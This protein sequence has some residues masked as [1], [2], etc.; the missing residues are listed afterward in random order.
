M[1]CRYSIFE[2][3]NLF[4]LKKACKNEKTHENSSFEFTQF[5]ELEREETKKKFLRIKRCHKML[6]EI[7]ANFILIAILFSF[8]YSTKNTNCFYYVTQIQN[9]FSGYQSVKSVQDLYN[10]LSNDF[11]TTLIADPSEFNSSIV[12]TYANFSYYLSDASSFVV[13]YPILR[14]LRIMKSKYLISERF[15]IT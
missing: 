1:K 15:F 10:W 11:L 9:S 8:I 4:F 2:L 3:L 14:Q 12:S 5:E 13:G 6:R 7:I